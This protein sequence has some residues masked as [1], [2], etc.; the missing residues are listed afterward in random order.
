MKRTLF[1]LLAVVVVS[2]GA[3]AVCAAEEDA[4][5]IDPKDW[6]WWRG[7]GRNGIAADQRVPVEWSETKNVIWKAAVPGRGHAS[8]IVVGTR[9][10]LESAEE[11]DKTQS[12]VCYERASGRE[13][14]RQELHK[15]GFDGR[16]HGKNTRA[17]STLASDGERVFAVFYNQGSIWATALGLDGTKAWQAKLGDFESHWGYS[18]SPTIHKSLLIVAADHKKAGYLVA[19]DRKTGAERWRAPRPAEPTYASP[20]VYR[21]A[22]KD[23]LLIAGA[24][25]IASYDPDTGKPL[26]SCKGTSTECVSS[27]VVEGDLLF[28][29]GGYPSKE[30]VCVQGDGSGKVLWRVP[31]GCFVPSMLVHRG[32]LYGVLD[33]GIAICWKADSG[34]ETW[35]ERLAGKFSGSPVLAGEHIYVPSEA[36]K[37]FVFK[38]NPDKFELVAQNQLG[39][40][41]F[42]SP[43]ICGGRIYLRVAQQTAPWQEM[44][45]CIGE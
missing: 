1:G 24:N 18:A 33:D 27:I 44:L 37:I 13:L 40:G 38:A 21:L 20:V 28:A 31:V 25:L 6:P 29:T 9:V 41:I 39:S 11:K 34:K 17:S 45:Y 43:V 3:S 32:A 23:Q 16:W 12:V 14:W 30:T 42:A 22:G 8:P 15:G 36:G 2:T 19:L 4:V 5:R 10:F 35:K 26:W 7:P